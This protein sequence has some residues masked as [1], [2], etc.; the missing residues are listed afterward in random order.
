MKCPYCNQEHPDEFLFCPT[1]GNKI[2]TIMAYS[3]G[4]L[5]EYDSIGSFYEGLAVVRKDGKYGVMDING[6]MI[7]P[8]TYSNILHFSEGLAACQK[9]SGDWAFMNLAGKIVLSLPEGIDVAS[10]IGFKEGLC[11][12]SGYIEDSEDNSVLKYGFIDDKGYLVI[13]LLYDYAKDFAGGFAVVTIEDEDGYSQEIYINKKGEKAIPYEYWACH[14]FVG[15]YAIAKNEFGKWLVIDKNAQLIFKLKDK[16]SK[17]VD[18]G[19]DFVS[20]GLGE[21]LLWFRPENPNKHYYWNNVRTIYNKFSEGYLAVCSSV[22][23][24]WGF[25]TDEGKEQIPFVYEEAHDFKEGL[26][27]VKVDGLWGFIGYTGMM[28]VKPMYNMVFDFSESRA[29]AK[30]NNRWIV[31]DKTGKII[32][33]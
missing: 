6:S 12:V 31:I 7:V 5:H 15:N 16:D 9:E 1:T 14:D 32:V 29:V 27:A 33:G 21:K 10:D 30:I 11:A 24:K 22:N 8:C 28:I 25:I 19:T 3:K 4:S 26:A 13:G 17:W 23:G 20:Y 2:E 18:I